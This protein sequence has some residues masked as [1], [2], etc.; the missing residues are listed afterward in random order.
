MGPEGEAAC[1]EARPSANWYLAFA[2]PA[3]EYVKFRA[4][5]ERQNVALENVILRNEECTLS[6]T[7]KVSNICFRKGPPLL[8]PVPR[9][10]GK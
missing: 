10:V 1:E 2:Q 5:L 7:I 6:G 4:T 8:L 9:P 3:S